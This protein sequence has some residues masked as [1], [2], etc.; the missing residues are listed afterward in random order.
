MNLKSCILVMLGI[1]VFMDTCCACWTESAKKT[2]ACIV[3]QANVTEVLDCSSAV[4]AQ[5]VP[6][7][8]PLIGFL[9]LGANGDIHA[10]EYLVGLEQTIG[11]GVVACVAQLILDDLVRQ[12]I[13]IPDGGKSLM[14][15]DDVIK[16]RHV[17]TFYL[18]RVG[19][20]VMLTFPGPH[21]E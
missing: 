4:V 5:A 14:K 15:S 12:V 1:F 11:I 20:N 10:A 21:K 18:Q 2:P 8:G 19:K 17:L 16:M 13:E 6:A 7:L 3:A 9:I